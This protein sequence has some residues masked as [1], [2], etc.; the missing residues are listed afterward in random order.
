MGFP[1][2]LGFTIARFLCVFTH[3][4]FNVNMR[5]AIARCADDF[6][7]YSILSAEDLMRW[8]VDYLHTQGGVL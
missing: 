1:H 8:F 3:A 7:N 2:I 4:Y 5:L 6:I